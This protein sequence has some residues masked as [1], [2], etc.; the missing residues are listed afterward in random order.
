M[1]QE[2][3]ALQINT[4]ILAVKLD[5]LTTLIGKSVI[6]KSKSPRMPRLFTQGGFLA[7]AFPNSKLIH[8]VRDGRA[9]SHSLVSR[10][11]LACFNSRGS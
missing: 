9:I 11:D 3:H 7:E 10:E 5:L 2:S 6:L 8:M 4:P 1:T